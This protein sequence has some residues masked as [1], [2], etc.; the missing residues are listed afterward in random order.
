MLIQSPVDW[1]C[2]AGLRLLISDEP[3]LNVCDVFINAATAFLPLVKLSSNSDFF[4]VQPSFAIALAL[5]LS[6]LYPFP[7][8]SFSVVILCSPL[9]IRFPAKR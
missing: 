3:N 7:G 2:C 4:L 8:L 6:P 9:L 1:V 5:S